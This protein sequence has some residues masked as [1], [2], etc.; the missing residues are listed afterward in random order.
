MELVVGQFLDLLGRRSVPC[1]LSKTGIDD[2]LQFLRIIFLNDGNVG[3]VLLQHTTVIGK[4]W[5][6]CHQLVHHGSQRPNIAGHDR[7]GG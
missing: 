4:G 5:G 6:A 1:L 2:V 3:T 7:L